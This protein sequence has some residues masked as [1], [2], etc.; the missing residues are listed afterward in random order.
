MY[1]SSSSWMKATRLAGLLVGLVFID[2]YSTPKD[3]VSIELPFL[4]NATEELHS[5]A[6][7]VRRQLND[8]KYSAEALRGEDPPGRLASIR[9]NTLESQQ[10]LQVC[11]AWGRAAVCKA[12]C[13]GGGGD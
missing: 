3:F 11:F 5:R 10:S 1:V 12:S 8:V 13:G 9:D 2:Y 6:L 4:A 7:A